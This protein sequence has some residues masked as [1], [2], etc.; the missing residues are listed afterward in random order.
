M[1]FLKVA[2]LSDNIEVVAFPRVLKEHETILA[3]G[4]CIMLKGKISERNGT[5]SFVAE[6]AKAL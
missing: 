2:D 6:K 4:Q 5:P 3:P 1:M